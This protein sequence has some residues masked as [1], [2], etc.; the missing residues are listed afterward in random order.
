MTHD[1]TKLV[2][3]ARKSAE[4]SN[5]PVHRSSTV[6]FHSLEEFHAAGKEWGKDEPYVY[7]RISNPNSREFEDAITALE[8]GYG[9]ISFCSGLSAISCCLLAF[10]SS[11]DH[12]LMVDTV[13]GPT[14][15]FCDNHLKRLGVGVEYYDPLLSADE[16]RK[17]IQA[18][19]RAI[20]LESPG[21]QTFEIQDVPAIAA[22]ARE[23][24]VLTMIDNTWATPLY[25]KPLAH[26]VNISIHSATKYI[27]G[28]SDCSLGVAAIETKE[29]WSRIKRLTNDNG[30]CAA[31]DQLYL[32]IRGLR[33]LDVRLKRHH[34]NALRVAEWLKGRK[35]VARVLYPA[36]PNDP[37]HGLWKRD[38]T[39]A[40]G[41]F[42]FE[43]AEALSDERLAAFLD[44]LEYFPL[45][46]SWGGDKSLA[47][48]CHLKGERT[49][50]PWEGTNPMLRLSIGLEHPDDL[51]ADL[52]G[53]FGRLGG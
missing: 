47:M 3:A 21:S 14:R 40:N 52:T 31:P 46:Y 8:G 1:Q 16:V 7:G 10:L 20:F 18:N 38:F 25:F 34:E 39:G 12:L 50:T 24:G 53:A 32:G 15:R 37:S 17:R 9:A 4:A 13:Y 33:T 23:H 51:I 48:P 41:L 43:F 5:T 28:H 2:H 26:G 11:G 29:L 49:A 44:G 27:A 36:L 6:L 42:S 35:E 19:T 30:S 45:G 22:V